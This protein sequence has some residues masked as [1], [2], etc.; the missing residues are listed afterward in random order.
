MPQGSQD[1]WLGPESRAWKRRLSELL[2]RGRVADAVRLL[3]RISSDRQM[4]LFEP[5][6]TVNARRRLAWLYKINLLRSLG[7]TREAL[8]WT[9]LECELCPDNVA[10]QALKEQLKQQLGFVPRNDAATATSYGLEKDDIWKGVAGMR[11]LKAVLERD[12]VLPLAQPELYRKYRVPLPNGILLYGPPGC[13]KTFIAQKLGSILGFHFTKVR[14]SDL[15]SIYVHG[16]QGKIGALFRSAREKAPCMLFFDELD[17]LLPVRDGQ[18]YHHYAAEVNE[19]L[20]QLDKASEDRVLVVGATN[21]LDRIDSAAIRAGRFDKKVF[22]GQPDLEARVELLSLYMGDRPQDEIDF[23]RMGR[24][25]EGYT[26]AEL[27]YVVNEA[28]RQALEHR[29]P[30][31]AGDL[32]AALA[33][34]PPAH[35]NEQPVADDGLD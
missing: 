4:A 16:S 31:S 25:C 32:L 10:A 18:L 15:G 14:P 11:E 6:F 9:C 28:A 7:R 33:A 35:A 13:G 27:E 5:R 22:V 20:T 23:V 1:D 21:R 29:R 12:V 2:A 24:E 8:A 17:A 34:N 26:C 3:D 19:F 30:I